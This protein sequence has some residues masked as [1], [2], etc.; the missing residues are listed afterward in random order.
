MR[1]KGPKTGTKRRRKGQLK[2]VVIV[3]TAAI[4]F[5]FAI[6]VFVVFVVSLVI[7]KVANLIPITVLLIIIAVVIDFPER[8]RWRKGRSHGGIERHLGTWR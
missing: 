3:I 7:V 6:L 8:I 4:I 5:P 2:Q 1:K